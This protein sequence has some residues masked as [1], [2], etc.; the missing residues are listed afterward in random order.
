MN[1][2]MKMV[3]THSHREQSRRRSH[4]VRSGLHVIETWNHNLET[5]AGIG[6]AVGR[7]KSDRLNFKLI[8][9]M[10]AR[11]ASRDHV[12]SATGVGNVSA[13]HFKG[14]EALVTYR[15]HNVIGIRR[16]T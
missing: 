10:V 12:F 8:V 6:Y 2:P 3:D 16:C 14:A 9:L 13:N 1:M 4:Y 7:A 15:L 11:M 5:R